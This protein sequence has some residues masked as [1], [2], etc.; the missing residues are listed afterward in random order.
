MNLD[1]SRLLVDDILTAKLKL[2][3]NLY[4]TSSS[5]KLVYSFPPYVILLDSTDQRTKEP[6]PFIYQT[7]PRRTVMSLF[8]LDLEVLCANAPTL[9]RT[10]ADRNKKDTDSLFTPIDTKRI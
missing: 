1:K 9:A 6:H 3:S 8:L 5:S 7:K 4:Q 10:A 2:T